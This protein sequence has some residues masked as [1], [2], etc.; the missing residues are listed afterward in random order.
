[1]PQNK[2]MKQTSVER[3]GRSQLIPGVLR[4]DWR[5]TDRS[6]DPERPHNGWR[7]DPRWRCGGSPT[8]ASRPAT[9]MQRCGESPRMGTRVSPRGSGLAPDA[10]GGRRPRGQRRVRR[11][12]NRCPCDR[13]HGVPPSRRARLDR[14]CSESRPR[15]P[16]RSAPG[17]A[18]WPCWC[19]CLR[20]FCGAYPAGQVDFVVKGKSGP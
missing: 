9:C 4:T 18:G 8:M 1:M 12:C 3:I 13:R 19:R 15:C 11:S 20:H 2:G 6:H 7:D 16:S 5:R 14:L 17:S 10:K